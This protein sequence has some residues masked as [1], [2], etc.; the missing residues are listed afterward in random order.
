M[1]RDDILKV[2]SQA[3]VFR[4]LS[5]DDLKLLAGYA[6]IEPVA[7]NEAVIV[8]GQRSEAFYVVLS[9]SVK[10]MLEAGPDH[11]PNRFADVHL[12]TLKPGDCCGEYSFI[13]AEPASATVIALEPGE[14]FKLTR[15]TFEH[16]L[17]HH[18]R[19]VRIVYCNLL[20]MLVH[21]LRSKDREL[22]LD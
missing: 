16:S 1:L 14:L 6:R 4:G 3:E 7:E 8:E 18:H 20:R 21:R 2:L 13:D 11:S 19:V 17:A 9:G 5:Q 15:T 12:A 22:D 10:V